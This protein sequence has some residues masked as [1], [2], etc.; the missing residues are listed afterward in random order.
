MMLQDRLEA[1]RRRRA[2][3]V[4]LMTVLQEEWDEWAREAEEWAPVKPKKVRRRLGPRRGRGFAPL[5]A[6]AGVGGPAAAWL[7]A[8]AALCVWASSRPCCLPQGGRPALSPASSLAPP[9]HP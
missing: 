9:S 6:A 7:S 4:G 5:R 8:R 1:R 3:L 2:A